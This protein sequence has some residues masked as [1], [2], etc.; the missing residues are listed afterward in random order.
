MPGDPKRRFNNVAC[1][2]A[3]TS[4]IMANQFLDES[5]YDPIYGNRPVFGHPQIATLTAGGDDIDSSGLI[6]HCINSFGGA[7]HA[8]TSLPAP[9][10]LSDLQN[11]LTNLSCSFK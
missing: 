1:S 6:L 4:E 11:S 7:R 10:N 2:G 3:T 9:G 8:K 5:K